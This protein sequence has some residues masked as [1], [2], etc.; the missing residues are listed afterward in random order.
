MSSIWA[1]ESLVDLGEDFDVAPVGSSVGWRWPLIRRFRLAIPVCALLFLVAAASSPPAAPLRLAASIPVGV[2]A[3]VMIEGSNLYV[4]DIADGHDRIRAFGLDGDGLRWS[5]PA[6]EL[7]TET[8]MSYVAGRVIVSMADTDSAGEHT[9]AFDAST[10]KRL[11]TSDL[12]YAVVAAGGVLVESAPR[13]PGFNYPGTV[14]TATFRLLDARTGLTRWSVNVPN[15]CVTRLSSSTT[16]LVELCLNSSRLTAVDLSDGHTAAT[17]EVD[18]GEPADNFFLPPA[19]QMDEPQLVLIADTILVAHANA[20]R[21][22]IDAYAMSDLHV[23]WTG[24]AVVPGESIDQCG[25]DVCLSDG[26]SSGAA[27]DLLT[28]QQIAATPS[29]SATAP[30]DGSLI[31]VPI[32]QSTP[33]SVAAVL[34]PIAAGHSATLPSARDEQLAVRQTRPEVGG[35]HPAAGDVLL[36]TNAM[37]LARWAAMDHQAGSEAG[38]VEQIEILHDVTAQSCVTTAGYLACTTAVDRIS[39]WKL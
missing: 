39:L 7:A 36:A 13:P 2:D 34:R 18:L 12:G 4:Y 20:P 37:W 16:S 19:N 28:G 5:A 10:G 27:V 33:P 29:R 17:R 32:G 11:W 30:P 14:E 3:S 8:T 26:E 31:L 24:P 15:N 21:P 38:R 9:V 25:V 1:T 23:R 22:T 6:S 35:A